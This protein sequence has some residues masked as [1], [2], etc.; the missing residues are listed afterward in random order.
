MEKFSVF[1][2]EHGVGTVGVRA[3]WLSLN[4]QF[5]VGNNHTFVCDEVCSSLDVVD[6]AD[7]YLIVFDGFAT[8]VWQKRFLSEQVAAAAYAVLEWDAIHGYASV[9]I[10][11]QEL[12]G[13]DRMKNDFELH[14]IAKVIQQGTEH[15]FD[16]FRAVN[17]E[18]GSAA[19][20]S[21]SRDEAGKSETVVAVQV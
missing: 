5:G 11:R 2:L 9:F 16:V 14:P 10:D 20:Q 17:V 7:G 3:W 15:T 8:Y 4:D 6:L 19:Q 21:L 1:R 12:V 18:W 13:I